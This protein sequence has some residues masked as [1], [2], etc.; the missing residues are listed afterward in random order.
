MSRYVPQM[1]ATNSHSSKLFVLFAHDPLSWLSQVTDYLEQL[2]D[3]A[4]DYI[5]ENINV[6]AGATGENLDSI[7]AQ[8]GLAAPSE[9]DDVKE[10]DEAM[11]PVDST[12]DG[13]VEP[14]E[15]LSPPPV[16][17]ETEAAAEQVDSTP[18]GS[19]GQPSSELSDK[20]VE[21]KPMA[22]DTVPEDAPKIYQ[23]ISSEEEN[24]PI[25]EAKEI[26]EVEVAAVERKEGGGGG[27]E[28]PGIKKQTPPPQPP[29]AKEA[30][31]VQD[32]TKSQPHRP[33]APKQ[34]PPPPPPPPPTK[35]TT[36]QRAE[37]LP[38]APPVVKDPNPALVK[39]AKEAQ[40]EVR[41]LRRHML[42]LNKQ[43]ESVEAEVSAQR[44]ELE[45]AGGKFEKERAKAKEQR[46]KERKAHA[47]ELKRMQ[48]QHEATLMDQKLRLE[49][50]LSDMSQNLQDIEQTRMQ[51]GG[52]WD[53]ELQGAVERE[54]F[55]SRQ[56][57]ALE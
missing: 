28:E 21:S 46:D 8:R 15:P 51:E 41:T 25:P 45:E 56:N 32:S 57:V 39:E 53:K 49:K 37:L 19:S 35:E 55:L 12:T 22:E 27:G 42:T 23:S 40:K 16:S 1:Q 30:E 20:N 26:P 47:D 6:D 29:P 52:N 34:V 44:K 24:K 17:D 33:P 43:L 36:K 48:T 7:L 13:T 18:P 2:D 5:E 11:P 9:D 31:E 10:E 50:Q 4:E 38:P 3:Q 14:I 54:Q